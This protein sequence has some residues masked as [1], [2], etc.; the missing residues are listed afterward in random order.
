MTM[1]K[2]TP[3]FFVNYWGQLRV[4]GHYTTVVVS[5]QMED[6]AQQAVHATM[7]FLT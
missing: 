6:D 5:T 7:G 2:K 4:L 1:I 3:C